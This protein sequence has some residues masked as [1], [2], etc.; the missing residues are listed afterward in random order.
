MALSLKSSQR[1]R[2][3][4]PNFIRRA[5]QFIRKRRHAQISPDSQPSQGCRGFSYDPRVSVIHGSDEQWHCWR[6]IQ[7]TFLGE[8]HETR[9]EISGNACPSVSGF[10]GQPL[11]QEE[12]RIPRHISKRV[13]SVVPYPSGFRIGHY[14]SQICNG[15]PG[16]ITQRFE[17]HSCRSGTSSGC[18]LNKPAQHKII[19]DT[20]MAD[21]KPIHEP[22][23]P[24]RLL[25]L[26][27]L[28]Q[29][30][31]SVSAY[32]AY[33]LSRLLVPLVQSIQTDPLAQRAAVIRRF[34]LPR[35]NNPDQGCGAHRQQEQSDNIA[36]SLW[37]NCYIQGCSGSPKPSSVGRR[38]WPFMFF[39]TTLN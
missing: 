36:T 16:F 6:G 7:E 22:S 38:G 26:D 28:E 14:P 20:L 31:K 15:G 33:G 19:R 8:L 35:P 12:N 27:P 3:G 1:R 39:M 21:F 4:S 2:G 10:V 37:S 25:V 18:P 11:C 29:T 34:P 30:G 17:P 24:T 13:P 5:G 32:L 9:T 23:P